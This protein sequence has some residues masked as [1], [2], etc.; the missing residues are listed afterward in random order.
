MVSVF[1][2]IYLN[3]FRLM[4]LRYIDMKEG[5]WIHRIW[6]KKICSNRV[7]WIPQTVYQ[8]TKHENLRSTWLAIY[9]NNKYSAKSWAKSKA[10]NLVSI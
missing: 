4:W 7:T 10:N 8:Q 1:V 2:I 6:Q 3:S 9:S 5:G